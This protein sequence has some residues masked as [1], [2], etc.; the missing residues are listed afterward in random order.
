MD[1]QSI[2]NRNWAIKMAISA[3]VEKLCKLLC[4]HFKYFLPKMA[5]PRK[6]F[7]QLNK[8]HPYDNGSNEFKPCFNGFRV[9]HVILLHVT[10]LNVNLFHPIKFLLPCCYVHYGVMMF[11]F[12]YSCL[13][14][15][16]FMLH[17]C[18]LYFFT[19]TGVQGDFH[20]RWC[21]YCWPVT[22][23]CY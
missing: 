18:Y 15:R 10:L 23:Q 21:S 13:C 7:K 3:F 16:W 2:S 5:L 11:V 22:R 17:L 12:F 14:S 8:Y 9:V 6:I 1:V 19:D 4:L 20:I